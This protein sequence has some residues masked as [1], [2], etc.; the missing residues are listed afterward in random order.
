MSGASQASA[1]LGFKPVTLQATV[2]QAWVAAASIN[3][4]W[5]PSERSEAARSQ[6]LSHDMPNMQRAKLQ[7]LLPHKLHLLFVIRLFEAH[8]IAPSLPLGLGASLCEAFQS[9]TSL[10]NRL[11]Q[12][13][14]S[15][16]AHFKPWDPD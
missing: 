15:R 16:C 2:A 12:Q 10:S 3:S 5:R 13:T 14:L 6:V 1:E 11:E 8:R 9:F 7:P 4:R